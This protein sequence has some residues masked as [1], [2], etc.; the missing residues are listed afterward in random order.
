MM[1]SSKAKGV[2]GS[3][4]R[5]Q[6]KQQF[7]SELTRTNWNNQSQLTRTLEG[8][9]GTS[10]FN[11]TKGESSR[12]GDSWCFRFSKDDGDSRNTPREMG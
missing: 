2:D 1:S 12:V 6:K 4:G 7:K 5:E 11:S 9:E 10:V 8:I 3:L